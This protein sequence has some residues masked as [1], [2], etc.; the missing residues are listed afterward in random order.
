MAKKTFSGDGGLY[1]YSRLIKNA[2]FS[3]S[4]RCADDVALSRGE[5]SSALFDDK[6]E[7]LLRWSLTDFAIIIMIIIS[8]FH[9]DDDDDGESEVDLLE[10]I[11]Y[12]VSDIIELS[13]RS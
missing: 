1:F 6:K 2:I 12:L 8:R 10:K 7:I 11:K 4:S 9:D 5:T 3:S 13:K